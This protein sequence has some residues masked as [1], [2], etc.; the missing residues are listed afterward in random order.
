MLK[1]LKHQQYERPHGKY[2]C[3]RAACWEKPCFNGPKPDGSCGGATECAPVRIGERWECRRPV[4]AGGPCAIGPKPDG[5]CSQCRPPCSPRLSLR[6]L[7]GRLVCSAMAAVIACILFWFHFGGTG[8]RIAA[9]NPGPLSAM[10]QHLPSV[11][12]PAKAN[13]GASPNCSVCHTAHAAGAAGWIKAAFKPSQ[14]S[15]QCLACHRFGNPADNR[16]QNSQHNEIFPHLS[17]A[18]VTQCQM[19]HTEHHGPDAKITLFTD[20]QCNTCHSRTIKSFDKDH[21][22]FSEFFPHRE[23]SGISFNHAKHAGSY[24]EA[25]KFVCSECHAARRDER[26]TGEVSFEQSC[27][28][29]HA[30]DIPANDLVILHLPEKLSQDPGDITALEKMLFNDAAG[31]KNFYKELSKSGAVLQNRLQSRSGKADLKPLFRSIKWEAVA[32]AAALLVSKG[33]ALDRNGAFDIGLRN[34]GDGWSWSTENSDAPELHYRAT[35]HADPVM[36]AW[37]EFGLSLSPELGNAMFDHKQGPG[38]C[39]KCHVAGTRD[40]MKIEWK[41]GRSNNE[42]R[43][44]TFSHGKHLDLLDCKGCHALNPTADLS[45]QFTAGANIMQAGARPVSSFKSISL[46]TCSQCHAEKKVSQSCLLCHRYHSEPSL[47]RPGEVIAKTDIP[48]VKEQDQGSAKKEQAAQ[49]TA[50]KERAQAAAAAKEKEQTQA[51]SA[52]ATAKEQAQA[53]AAAREQAKKDALAKEQAQA[54]ANT[55]EQEQAQAAAASAKEQARQAALAKEQAQAAAIASEQARKAALAKEQAAAAAKEQAQAQAAAAAAKEQARQEARAREQAQADAAAKEKEQAALAKQQAQDAAAAAAAKSKEQAQAVAPTAVATATSTTPATERF[56]GKFLGNA[57]CIGCHDAE[58]GVWENTKHKNSVN[59]R[60]NGNKPEVKAIL[61]AVNSTARNPFEEQICLK[62]HFTVITDEPKT[63]LGVSCESCHGAASD[64][65]EIHN[66]GKDDKAKHVQ[67]MN[68]ARDKG[69]INSGMKQELVQ[70]CFGC[71]NYDRMDAGTVAKMVG[72]G[73][74]A[75]A[76][77]FVAFSQGT[78]RHRFYPPDRNNNSEMAPAELSR[79]YVIGQGAQLVSSARVLNSNPD[80]VIK[81]SQQAKIDNAKKA[82]TLSGLQSAKALMDSPTD[83]NLKA[84]IAECDGKDFS[85]KLGD[86]LPK[87][88]K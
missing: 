74:P 46:Q 58:K 39:A 22:Q 25:G 73:H 18:T 78:V 75:F 76:F 87:E 36:R 59:L 30:K 83:D 69:M 37:L 19:C 8:H 44:T 21:P 50:T 31:M 56:Q 85:S 54:A 41:M 43:H 11:V 45:T 6:S 71:H 47:L 52:A 7:R 68:A 9:V 79:W 55:K 60:R 62:C 5:T 1:K 84:L 23:F 24:F 64:W 34:A 28:R 16:V 70:N 86:L 12:F 13:G 49:E 61:A 53:A 57:K 88:F 20:T 33:T 48:A 27:S 40:A 81:D 15:A 26:V 38:N 32:A 77:E 2:Q 4:A 14:M 29:C 42:G 72:A 80:G 82:L 17:H 3:G 63:P 66:S 65:I 10:H 51:A 35:A 67:Q